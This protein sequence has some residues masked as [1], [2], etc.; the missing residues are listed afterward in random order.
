MFDSYAPLLGGYCEI[1][2]GGDLYCNGTL[3]AVVK[4]DKG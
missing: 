1:D 2:T 4:A 3:N